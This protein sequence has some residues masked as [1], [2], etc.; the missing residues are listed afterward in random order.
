[1]GILG[2]LK[3]LEGAQRDCHVREYAGLRAA[4]DAHGWLHAGL[5]TCAL[6]LAT[7]TE[8]QAHI[9]F[10][11][12]RVAMLR[13]WGVDPV[14]VFDGEPLPAK[15]AT[16]DERR[17][18]RSEQRQEGERLM[19]LGDLAGARSCFMQGLAV[20]PEM[21]DALVRELEAEGTKFIVA[22]YEA[23]AQMAF[24]SKRG[25]VDVCIS[26]DS[27]LLA[28]GC[29]RVLF[30]LRSD[31]YGKEIQLQNALESRS[32]EEFQT[33]CILM[34][35]D[36]LSRLRGAGPKT[37]FRLVD[38]C[39]V[40]ANSLVR[41]AQ[42][43][44]LSVPPS[45]ARHFEEARL[46]FR[47]QLV[48]DPTTGQQ[49]PMTEALAAAAAAQEAPA[50]PEAS[51]P[52][53]EA[54]QPTGRQA[55][56]PPHRQSCSRSRSPYGAQH[57]ARRYPSSP[58]PRRLPCYRA[59]AHASHD[60][61]R[62]PTRGASYEQQEGDWS[63]CQVVCAEEDGWAG[64]SQLLLYDEGQAQRA[65]R[66]AFISDTWEPPQLSRQPRMTMEEFFNRERQRS[67]GP[68]T[69]QRQRPRE[70][71][72]WEAQEEE[73]YCEDRRRPAESPCA[74]D[75]LWTPRAEEAGEALQELQWPGQAP[76][77]PQAESAEDLWTPPQPAPRRPR[78]VP[79]ET[80][81]H[82][83]HGQLQRRSRFFPPSADSDI[84]GVAKASRRR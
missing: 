7:G 8:S 37:A 26:E 5:A 49:L 52:E 66:S 61:G 80:A 32:F 18:R 23:D 81:Q 6:E 9:S 17:R 1:M 58:S 44:G 15:R 20:G 11:V 41:E 71:E 28:H 45:Y 27:D 38:R 4:V 39:G 70:R 78:S 72:A 12:R 69:P 42:A 14:L 84:G 57:P 19:R 83:R 59:S 47:R 10:C 74:V 76:A 30:K 36:Y 50:S 2:L 3:A 63:S 68:A 54:S 43:A 55:A 67:R 31:G 53:R 22:P 13:R 51:A 60:G 77:T 16:N 29:K 56:Y 21:V 64:S 48:L 82:A 46:A 25:L 34:G 40:D 65:Q 33:A 62:R 73:A 75:E 35:C 24:L 79:K